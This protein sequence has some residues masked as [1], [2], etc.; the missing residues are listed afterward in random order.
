MTLQHLLRSKSAAIMAAGLV[1]SAFIQDSA[2]AVPVID[3]NNPS[4]GINYCTGSCEWQQEITAG[5]TGQLTGLQLFG[6]GSARVRIAN[7][8]G[9]YAGPWAAEFQTALGEASAIGLGAF[10]IFVTAG[11]KY[12]VDITATADSILTGN[13]GASSSGNLYLNWPA[14][15]YNGDNYS[16]RGPYQLAYVTY[17]D[18]AVR[19]G[20]AVPEPAALSLLGAGLLGLLASRKRKR[21]Q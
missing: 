3:G 11:Q 8:S 19:P 20:Q 18:S 4:S 10:D 7:S 13:Y 6:R 15:G 1:S 5:L 9:F 21:K 16:Q 12:V 2:F 14:V 17:V